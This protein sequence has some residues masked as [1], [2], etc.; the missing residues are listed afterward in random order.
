VDQ[1]SLRVFLTMAN[2]LHFG[3]TGQECNLSPSAVSRT[4]LRLEDELGRPLFTRDN[5]SVELTT[6]GAEFRRYA[7]EV[8][9]GWERF[10]KAMSSGGENL[11]GELKLYCSV[12]ASYTVLADLFR[13]FREKYP[14]V[15]IRLQTGDSAAAI[16]RV[17]GGEADITVAALPGFLPRHLAFKSV[18]VTPLLFIAPT[19]PSDAAEITR[20]SPVPWSRVPMILSETGLSRKRVDAWFR[21][22]GIKPN[23]YAEVAGHEAIVSMVRLG[24][25]VAVVPRL[26]LDRFSLDGEVRVIDAK[27]PLEPYIVG[28]CALKRRL[29]S[30]VV[31]AF[32]EIAGEG[33]V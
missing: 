12:A 6:A 1:H 8:L 18:I 10:R 14:D 17:M 3:R 23:V 26:V 16:E 22:G 11:A 27:P 7:T 33:S 9:D 20:R 31:K 32:W 4:I 2:A 24:C 5:R 21:A 15:R 29:S 19:V 30:P 28:L 25:G 13:A